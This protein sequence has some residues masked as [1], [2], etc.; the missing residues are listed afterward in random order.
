MVEKDVDRAERLVGGC[1][2]G[3]D[4]VGFRD[5]G[6]ERDGDATGAG[7]FCGGCLGC[8]HVD[9]NDGDFRAFSGKEF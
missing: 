7:D 6:F 4:L 1:N 8:L 5:I 3:V 2:C 9:I